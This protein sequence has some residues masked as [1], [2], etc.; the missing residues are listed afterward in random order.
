MILRKVA[1]IVI[2]ASAAAACAPEPAAVDHPEET[3]PIRV[4]VDPANTEQRVMGELYTRS[5]VRHG[6]Q[7][8]IDLNI[9]NPPSIETLTSGESDLMVGCTGS[10]LNELNP[11]LAEQL[12]KQYVADQKAGKVDKNSGT[13][14]DKVNKEMVG[15]LPGSLAA[16]NPSDTKGCEHYDG[17]ELPQNLVPIYR[18]P[19]LDRHS[20]EVVNEV[21]GN[22][23][24]NDLK[25]L[26]NEV[27]RTSSVSA[28]VEPYLNAKGL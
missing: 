8:Y 22:I 11:Q 6:R 18:K 16:P 28:A 17:P 20:R 4:A 10:I 3:A 19:M 25:Q 12:S 21:T 13:W 7:A 9:Q 27:D 14:R 24:Q 23:S 26:K 5:L 1:A 2:A 15:S